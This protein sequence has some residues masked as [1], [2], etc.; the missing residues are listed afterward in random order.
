MV[1]ASGC[2]CCL[3]NGL[4]KC[5]SLREGPKLGNITQ[6]YEDCNLVRIPPVWI[7][8][9]RG[10]VVFLSWEHLKYLQTGDV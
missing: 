9:L 10:G 6:A 5:K 3:C 7:S 4:V 8:T 2:H 1:Y